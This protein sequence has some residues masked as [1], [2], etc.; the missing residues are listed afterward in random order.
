MTS[1]SLVFNQTLR[2][3]FNLIVCAAPHMH[4]QIESFIISLLKIA[5]SK[6]SSNEHQVFIFVSF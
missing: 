1:N 2:T 6:N 5:E 4:E 3:M